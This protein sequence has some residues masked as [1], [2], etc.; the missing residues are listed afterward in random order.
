MA[1]YRNDFDEEFEYQ[2]RQ[3]RFE[4]ERPWNYHQPFQD[5]GR[6]SEGYDRRG[7]GRFG[8]RADYEYNEPRYNDYPGG[9]WSSLMSAICRTAFLSVAF[10]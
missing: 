6:L 5:R 9:H 3:D 7:L 8:E 2:S 1:R 10:D 4:R